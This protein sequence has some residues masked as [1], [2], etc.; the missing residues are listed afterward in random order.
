MKM[1]LRYEYRRRINAN[2]GILAVAIAV[3]DGM[4]SLKGDGRQE[5]S[6]NKKRTEN[7]DNTTD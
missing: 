6:Y 2:A 5:L 3:S 1:D 7:L 4:R